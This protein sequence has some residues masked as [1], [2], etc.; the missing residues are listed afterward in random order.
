MKDKIKNDIKEISQ[1]FLLGMVAGVFPIVISI[2][3][4]LSGVSR[5]A[6]FIASMISW[7]ISIFLIG[8][9]LLL[10][11]INKKLSERKKL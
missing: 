6:A 2:I 11:D 9:L 8:I 4:L 3:A 1:G 10:F 5:D 7:T